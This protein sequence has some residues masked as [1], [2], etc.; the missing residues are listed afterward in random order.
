MPL[1]PAPRSQ[2]NHFLGRFGV[3]LL[4]LFIINTLFGLLPLQLRDPAWQLRITDLLRTT[5]PFA[6]LGAVLIFLCEAFE[7]KPSPDWFTVKRI[8]RLAPVAA[9]GFVLLI[10]LQINASWVQIRTADAEAQKTIRAVQRRVTAVRTAPSLEALVELSKGLPPDWQPKAGDSL[11]QN[12]FR[13]LSRAEPELARLRTLSLSNKSAAIQR[14][15]QEGLRDLL[16]NLIYA[17][18]FFGAEPLKQGALMGNRGPFEWKTLFGAVKK[19][20]RR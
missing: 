8:K 3:A 17:A 7:G 19:K 10:P 4:L 5:A 1:L 15:L 12:R 13:I 18:A 16:L 2:T 20:R 14:R 11:A 6:I 9:V